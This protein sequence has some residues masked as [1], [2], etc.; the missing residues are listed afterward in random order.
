MSETSKDD[1]PKRGGQPGNRNNLRHGLKAGKLPKN[2]AY[3][4][5]QINKLRRQIED[6]VVGLKGEI[7]LMDAAAIQTAIKWERHGAL[8]LRWLNKEADV[9]KPTE[10]LQFSREIARASTERDK[11]IKE[12]G[13]DMKPEPIDLNSYL[14]NGTDQ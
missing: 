5:V 11:A 6:A 10:R 8:A 2:A 13:L 14:T 1:S 3:I 9:L 4:E 7:S 12:L